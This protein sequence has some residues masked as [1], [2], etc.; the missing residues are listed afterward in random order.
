M[1]SFTVLITA[2]AII[3]ALCWIIPAQATT[4]DQCLECHQ[5]VYD[6]AMKKDNV[7]PWFIEKKCGLC[8]FNKGKKVLSGFGSNSVSANGSRKKI[9]VII[10]DTRQTKEH[11]FVLPSKVADGTVLVNV[12]QPNKVSLWQNVSMPPLDSLDA[13]E[14]DK[15]GPKISGVRIISI[16]RG[17]FISATVE[18]ETD[19]FA[20][21]MVVYSLP[22]KTYRSS[23]DSQLSKQHRLTIIGLKAN[24]E[25]TFSVMS[26]DIF[27]NKTASATFT[28]NTRK[29]VVSTIVP[30]S[31]EP[32][33][34]EVKQNLE[35]KYFKVGAGY[36]LKVA[37]QQPSLMFI[38]LVNTADE[39]GEVK[40][41]YHAELCDPEDLH[42][43]QCLNCHDK[44]QANSHPINIYARPD[45]VIPSEY[46]TLADGRI[47]CTTCHKGHGSS[48]LY[49]TLKDHNRDLCTGCHKEMI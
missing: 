9:K 31:F 4:G 20:D 2:C 12:D 10:K 25:Y 23:L 39:E 43:K 45:M 16:Q 36:L 40:A 18:W 49:L 41:A 33:T 27:G 24:N 32:L 6:Q 37:S 19:K 48:N 46:P 5:D 22:Q 11:W 35:I 30:K 38:G 42:I 47:S 44:M 17:L 1:E 7:H 26:K 3:L 8:H 34:K 13:I 21:G 29:A 14:N 15:T 28:F